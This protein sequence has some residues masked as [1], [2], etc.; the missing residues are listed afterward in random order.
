MNLHSLQYIRLLVGV[1]YNITYHNRNYVVENE[2]TYQILLEYNIIKEGEI[3]LIINHKWTQM[4]TSIHNASVHPQEQNIT[5]F[6][7]MLDRTPELTSQITKG[8]REYD[9]HYSS[10]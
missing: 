4:D 10:E 2:C 7:Y 6:M 9:K 3:L 1:D 8:H 5:T